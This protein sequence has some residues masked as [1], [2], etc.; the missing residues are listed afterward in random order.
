M[1]VVVYSEL[2]HFTKRDLE[3]WLVPL[4]FKGN[5]CS[6]W[7]QV[8]GPFLVCTV[9]VCNWA[10]CWDVEM[11]LVCRNLTPVLFFFFTWEIL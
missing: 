2:D 10:A 5:L 9:I 8:I 1:F 6:W 7:N 4:K 3:E 11:L